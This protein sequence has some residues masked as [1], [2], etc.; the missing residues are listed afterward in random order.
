LV[1]HDCLTCVHSRNH[2]GSPYA[3]YGIP[4]MFRSFLIRTGIVGAVNDMSLI[5]GG[6]FD[7]GPILFT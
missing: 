5:Y 7:L 3:N 4:N 1:G 2:Y 6:T